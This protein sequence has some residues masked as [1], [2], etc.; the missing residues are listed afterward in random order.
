MNNKT[1]TITFPDGNQYKFQPATN[2]QCQQTAPITG[3]D[4][5]YNKVQSD[6]VTRGATLILSSPTRVLPKVEQRGTRL[7]RGFQEQLFPG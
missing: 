7:R 6:S 4:I 3:G 1:V 5:V 2:P